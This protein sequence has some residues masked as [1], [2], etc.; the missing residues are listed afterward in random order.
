[1]ITWSR[2][3]RTVTAVLF[4]VSVVTVVVRAPAGAAP[5]GAP[6]RC[7]DSSVRLAGLERGLAAGD[8]LAPFRVEAIL[9]PS[10]LRDRFSF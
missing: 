9:R 6:E 2:T 1:M 8:E 7:P 4:A 3:V 10:R 5:S